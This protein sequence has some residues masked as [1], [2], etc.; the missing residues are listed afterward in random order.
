MT[1]QKV[2]DEGGR[3]AN[4]NDDSEA[5]ND[6][7]NASI[8]EPEACK[9]VAAE[10]NTE[11]I[12]G[13]STNSREGI[14]LSDVTASEREILQKTRARFISNNRFAAADTNIHQLVAYHIQSIQE[15]S[16]RCADYHEQL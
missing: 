11:V 12:V 15:H 10:P 7:G 5:E 1:R 14:T 3:D 9:E 4:E 13:D 8:A 6:N 16:N 2:S